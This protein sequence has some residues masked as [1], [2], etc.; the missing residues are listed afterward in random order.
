[1]GSGVYTHHESLQIE[2]SLFSSGV[3]KKVQMSYQGGSV[4]QLSD[5][6]H[7]CCVFGF[8]N[9]WGEVVQI[10]ISLNAENFP[11]RSFARCVHQSALK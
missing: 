11:L 8:S 6:K 3:D 9:S 7:Y 1:M 2:R 5:G 4:Q 10:P